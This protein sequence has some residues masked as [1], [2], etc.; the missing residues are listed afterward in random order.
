MSSNQMKNSTK[1]ELAEQKI[2]TNNVKRKEAGMDGNTAENSADITITP[3]RIFKAFQHLAY[4]WK[5]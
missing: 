4:R 2:K 3:Q 5:C 1:S